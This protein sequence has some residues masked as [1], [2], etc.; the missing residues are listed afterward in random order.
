MKK[1]WLFLFFLLWAPAVWAATEGAP[2]PAVLSAA[3]KG[4][5]D[6]VET[7]LNQLKSVSADFIQINDS[8]QMRHGK[9][10]IQRP[11]KMRVAYDAPSQDL[12]IADGTLV[13]MWDAELKQQ[14]NVPVGSS[15][16]EFILRDPIKLNGDVVMTHFVHRATTIEVTLVSQKDPGEGQLTLIF[17]DKPLQLRQWRVLDA[18]GR[19]TGV[20]LENAREG[21]SFDQNLFNF[22]APTFGAPRQ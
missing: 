8:G 9:I 19:T 10:M 16:A 13:H 3:D 1:L 4:L 5:A 12:I 7:Y 21:V 22:I 17:E 14:T 11:G 6:R 15:L 18:Q 20:S 2:V